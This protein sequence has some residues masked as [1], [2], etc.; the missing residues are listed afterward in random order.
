MIVRPQM[1]SMVLLSLLVIPALSFVRHSSTPRQTISIGATKKSKKQ[2]I[3]GND[4]YQKSLDS[5]RTSKK[6]DGYSVDE[7]LELLRYADVSRGHNFYETTLSN[8][9]K[10]RSEATKSSNMEKL[11]D[12]E[13][14][15]FNLM[16]LGYN[17]RLS[18]Q[19]NLD[20]S[21]SNSNLVSAMER[22]SGRTKDYFE[23]GRSKQQ[24]LQDLREQRLRERSGIMQI[25][26][27]SLHKYVD[28]VRS[29]YVKPQQADLVK[30]MIMASFFSFVVWANASARS[31]F[32]YLVIGKLALMSLLLARNMPQKDMKNPMAGQKRQVATWSRN[33]FNTAVGI[34]L[35]T[36]ISS[37]LLAFIT[38]SLLPLKIAMNGR[39]KFAMVTSLIASGYFTSFFEVFEEKDKNG[40]RW[41]KAMENALPADEQ[42]LLHAAVYGEKKFTEQYDY[43][44][45]PEIDDY[46]PLP[47][48]ID[49][50]QPLVGDEVDA[51]AAFDKFMVDKKER[52]RA[53]LMEAPPD[54]PG[55]GG[56]KDMYPENIPKWLK[57]AYKKNVTAK[58]KWSSQPQKFDRSIVE[59]TI[60]D[61]PMGFRDK[62]VDWMKSLFGAGIWEDKL[63][64]SRSAARAF[65]SYRKTMWKI[66]DQVKL[67]PAD[68]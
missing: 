5:L 32:M 52:A 3:M 1:K 66:D 26:P 30:N 67:Q 33:A 20:G 24:Q 61:G 23:L 57:V 9:N 17:R 62:K 59:V 15:Y 65:G 14:K 25:L 6:V 49:G 28:Y 47:K 45:N 16:N 12:I 22:A 43:E 7:E 21:N 53:P 36:S 35:C 63:G 34:T 27:E 37:G 8:V 56:K 58:N 50:D 48:Y 4:W 54:A 60:A 68:I 38:S 19:N 64:V 13:D 41:T 44:Y 40:W 29:L 2:S 11:L 39:L 31:S 18:V 42:E 46:P 10:M 51:A 55:F